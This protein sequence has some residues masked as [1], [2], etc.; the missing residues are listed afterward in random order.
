MFNVP[1]SYMPSKRLLAV[2]LSH[3]WE[4]DGGLCHFSSLLPLY[5]FRPGQICLLNTRGLGESPSQFL[6]LQWYSLSLTQHC[7]STILQLKN[8]SRILSPKQKPCWDILFQELGNLCFIPRSINSIL[9]RVIFSL[10]KINYT[11][12]MI[13]PKQHYSEIFSHVSFYIACTYF[14][15]AYDAQW[16]LSFNSLPLKPK[17]PLIWV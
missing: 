5:H 6:L 17:G 4:W 12:K 3:P 14:D 16:K 8:K 11:V 7:K 13:L 2:A 10:K 9:A 15:A 1:S